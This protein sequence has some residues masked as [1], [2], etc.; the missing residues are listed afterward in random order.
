M[1]ATYGTGY[2]TAA[3]GE[4]QALLTAN[5]YRPDN[6]RMGIVYCHSWGAVTSIAAYPY[7]GTSL[8][9]PIMLQRL[10]ECGWPVIVA[11]LGLDTWGSDTGIARVTEAKAYLQGV[12]GAKAGKVGIVAWSMGGAVSMAWMRANPTLVQAAY[13][14]QPV[15]DLNDLVVNNRS[16]GASSVNAAYPG[17]VYTDATDGPN[18]SPVKFAAQL[19]GIPMKIISASD[20][21]VVIPSTVATVAAATGAQTSI[22]TGGH[23]DGTLSKI[24]PLDVSSWLAAH[25]V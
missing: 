24:D 20:D 2:S 10:A 15:S 7:S 5:N 3:P 25:G 14:M 11:D 13:L 12:G 16:G 9:V 23:G 19:A 6:T 1:Q 21:A 18:H 17:G 8:Y 4:H 22:L